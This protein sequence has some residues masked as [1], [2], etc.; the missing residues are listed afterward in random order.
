MKIYART[1]RGNHPLYRFIHKDVW[2]KVTHLPT[3]SKYYI[4]VYN[5]DENGVMTF[6]Q[7]NIWPIGS[8]SYEAPRFIQRINKDYTDNVSNFEIVEPME[9]VSTAELYEMCGVF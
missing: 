6:N 4:R 1:S 3:E 7:T 2:V 8:E 9:L 5:I